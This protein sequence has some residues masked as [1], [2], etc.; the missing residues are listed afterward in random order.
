MKLSVLKNTVRWLCSTGL[1]LLFGAGFSMQAVAQTGCGG[2][3]GINT[4]PNTIINPIQL[5]QV[6][7]E[8]PL[9]IQMRPAAGQDSFPLRVEAARFALTCADN[10]DAVPCTYGNDAGALSGEIPIV[11]QGLD[12]G[13]PGTCAVTDVIENPA[14]LGPGTI[15]FTFDELT[16]DQAGCTVNFW[17]DVNDKGTDSTPLQLTP[18]AEADGICDTGTGTILSGSAAGSALILVATVP[19]IELLKEISIDG[20]ATWHDAN[21]A[22]TAPIAEFPSGA[23]YRLTVTNTGTAD[24]TDVVIN[25]ATLGISDV[26]I[27]DLTVG[28]TVI[29]GSGDIAALSSA[30]ACDSGGTFQNIASVNAVSVDDGSG[31]SD[32]DPANL[33]CVGMDVIK[34]GDTLAK[35]GDN[36][37]YVFTLQNLSDMNLSNCTAD[38]SVLGVVFGPVEV[39]APGSTDAYASRTALD[40]DPSTLF[41]VVTLNCDAVGAVNTVNLS[42]QDDHSV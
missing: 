8:F 30:T 12:L 33:T 3:I 4:D 25:D 31:V 23:E 24:L 13:D 28:E 16:L 7:E 5:N 14:D 15:R 9:R 34:S 29:L 1:I 11:F 39:L 42:A 10:D 19:D 27:A 36:V 2:S 40:T 21:D 35:V 41:N 38:D 22:S 26:A 18:A 6:P 17:V 20:G 37:E 32:N